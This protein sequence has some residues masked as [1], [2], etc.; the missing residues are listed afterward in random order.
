MVPVDSVVYRFKSF[1]E[2]LKLKF[3]Y[4]QTLLCLLLLNLAIS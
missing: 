2:K 4:L 1:L 3:Q